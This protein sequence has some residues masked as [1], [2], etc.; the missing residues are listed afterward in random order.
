MYSLALLSLIACG[1]DELPDP[2]AADDTGDFSDD[3]GTT[4]DD[5]GDDGSDDGGSDDGGDDDGSATDDGGSDDGVDTSNPPD[6]GEGAPMS[7]EAEY[8][9]EVVTV[10]RVRWTTEVP[11]RGYVT[12]GE[13]SAYGHE[14]PLTDE[15]TEHEVLLLG[16]P[17]ET[18]VHFEVVSVVDDGGGSEGELGSDELVIT[19]G[20]LP[21]ELPELYPS[22]TAA[23]WDGYIMLPIQGTVTV[24]TIIDSQGRYVWYDFLEGGGNLMRTFLSYDRDELIYCYAGDQ[25]HLEDGF[26]LKVGLDAE[27]TEEFAAPYIDHDMVELPDGTVAAIVVS[28][29]TGGEIAL[30]GSSADQLVE[31]HPD[32]TTSVI[33]DAWEDFPEL[34]TQGQNWTHGNGLDYHPEDDTYTM[35]LKGQ[36]M[37]I[38][39]DRAT[40]ERLW[41]LGGVYNDFRYIDGA[42]PIILHH[43]FDRLDDGMLIFDNGDNNRGY[44]RAVEYTFD[45][46][47]MTV[48]LAWEYVRD[49][50]VYVYAKGDVTRF[51]DGSTQVVWSSSGEIQDVDP[52]GDVTWELGVELGHIFQFVQHVDDLYLRD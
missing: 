12:F 2:P 45:M 18:Q 26:I 1:K 29:Y 27:T 50:P 30:N 13:S 5:S 47:E 34:A 22:G 33:W 11:T 23:S 42:E 9:E 28:P 51:D 46:D 17:A 21:S 4:G 31:F 24:A 7:I 48:A 19:T 39:I 49:P 41:T 36:S 44:S 8:L 20:N 16:M 32:G 3:T 15:G 25:S 14:T 10:V 38:R 35:S 37:M 52:D 40:G 6:D 43:Q